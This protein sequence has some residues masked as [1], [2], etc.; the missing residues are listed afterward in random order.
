MLKVLS[1]SF[2]PVFPTSLF[3]EMD[4]QLLT[5]VFQPQCWS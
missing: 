5:P 4:I 1:L 3:F 2:F